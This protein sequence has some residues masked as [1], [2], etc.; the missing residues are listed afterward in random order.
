M[1]A[2]D[3]AEAFVDHVLPWCAMKWLPC[4]TAILAHARPYGHTQIL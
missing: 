2:M 1:N 3:E 4:R